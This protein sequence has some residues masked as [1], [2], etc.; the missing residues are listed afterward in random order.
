MINKCAAEGIKYEIIVIDNGSSDGSISVFDHFAHILPDNFRLVLLKTNK[1]TTYPRN[2]GLKKAQGKY[3]CIL[4]SDTE[5]VKGE[6]TDVIRLLDENR[7][8]GIVAPRLLLENG[9]VQNSVK[10]F[11]TFWHKL[12]KIP[13][14]LFGI[15][16]LEV[17]FYNGFP[18]EKETE[19]DSAISACWF[20]RREL[21]E[22][23][24]MLDENIFYSPEDLD[25]CLRVYKAGK[26]ILF[27]PCV[28]L[29][30]FTQQISH[31]KPFSKV[32]LSHFRGL[33]YY[34]GKHGGWIFPPVI[35]DRIGNSPGK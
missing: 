27:F 9:S 1:G 11:P 21:L 7:E 13:K 3:I 29:I 25:Y 16:T 31:K 30:H 18:F 35:K 23:V 5:L 32:S 14:A 6:L 10:K 22:T 26:K 4:D 17:D 33:L 12:I 8:I 20:F 19:V 15:R 24:G 28:T 2:I 34:F